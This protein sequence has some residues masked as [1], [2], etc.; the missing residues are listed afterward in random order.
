VFSLGPAPELYKAK[1]QV[2]SEF[3]SVRRVRMRIE[4]VLRIT[5]ELACRKKTRYVP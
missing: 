4:E 2:S 1:F 5:T 3:R